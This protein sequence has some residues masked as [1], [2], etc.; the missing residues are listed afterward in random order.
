[1]Y[2]GVLIGY[3]PKSVTNRMSKFDKCKCEL[4]GGPYRSKEEIYDDDAWVNE[5]EDDYSKDY[6]IVSDK[7]DFNG[8]IYTVESK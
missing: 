5:L 8:R 1:M 2:D 7:K 3:V 6:R 4:Y